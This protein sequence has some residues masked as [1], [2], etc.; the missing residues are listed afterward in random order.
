MF[1]RKKDMETKEQLKSCV[2]EWIRLDNEIN[3]L[4]AEVK[5]RTNKKKIV[6]ET[7]LDVMKNHEIDC[8]DINGGAL[9]YKKS[10]I[11]K[12]ITAKVLLQSLQNYFKDK[13][14]VASDVANY[15]LENR[16]IEEKETV[17]RRFD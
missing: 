14:D 15:V 12:P 13:P 9:V 4:K 2:K 6:T 10:A 17:C 16:Q 8:F 3:K 11:K 7:L 1:E 5:E